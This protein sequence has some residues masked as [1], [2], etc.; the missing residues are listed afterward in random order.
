MTTAVRSAVEA[1]DLLDEAGGGSSSDEASPLER[2][3]RDIHVA[4]QHAAVACP[5]YE[6]VGQ[7]LRGLT[8]QTPFIF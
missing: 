5:S 4:A 1:V 6:T 8:P 3:F 2:C 7:V